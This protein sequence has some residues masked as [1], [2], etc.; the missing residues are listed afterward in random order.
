M[1]GGWSAETHQH[2]NLGEGVQGKMF[3]AFIGWPT[4][5]AH[6]AFRE[7]EGFGKI[8]GLLRGGTKGIKMWHVDFKQYR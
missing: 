3:A 2:E 6:M 8:I 7:T 1:I 4:I 5:E